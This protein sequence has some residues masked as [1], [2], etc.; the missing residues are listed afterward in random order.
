MGKQSRKIKIKNEV[1]ECPEELNGPMS[2]ELEC[3]KQKTGK[4]GE[5]ELMFSETFRK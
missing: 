4:E 5:N 1:Q 3:L 2:S